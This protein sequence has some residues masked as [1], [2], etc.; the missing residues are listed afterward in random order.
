MANK[1][2]KSKKKDAKEDNLPRNT[3]FELSSSCEKLRD[4][5]FQYRVEIQ[6]YKR[7]MNTLWACV[8]V[9][10][11]LLGFFGYNHVEALLDKVE[12]NASER[13]SKT[14]SLLATI[15]AR[16]LDSL[17]TM[18][19]ER[20]VAYEGAITALENGTR[21]NNE[22]YKKLISGLSSNK[23]T[24]KSVKSHIVRDATNVF[25]IV[26]Y[27]NPYSLNATGD[28]YIVM[29]EDYSY[30]K[31]DF[32]IIEVF[33]KNRHLALYFQ[34]FEVQSNYNKLYF[35]LDRKE[36]FDGYELVVVLIRKHNN[37]HYGYTM[38]KPLTVK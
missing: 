19:E 30:D 9:V 7:S 17:M 11:A 8:S 5:L 14:D 12:K 35:K 15:D 18:V 22:L 1:L 10:V 38:T 32:F 16:Y 37:E 33:P 26:Y 34:Q 4:E 28:C 24:D 20:T 3:E 29:G 23:R 13:L 36:Q 6:S 31:E 21:V 2:E 25:D 27:T